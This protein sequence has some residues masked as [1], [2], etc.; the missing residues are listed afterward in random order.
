MKVSTTHLKFVKIEEQTLQEVLKILKRMYDM[1]QRED[2][3][4]SAAQFLIMDGGD[5]YADYFRNNN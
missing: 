4:E 5:L 3:D 2:W 1:S